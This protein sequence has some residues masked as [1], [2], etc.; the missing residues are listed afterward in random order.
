MADF[1][2]T[3]PT[4]RNLQNIAEYEFD[5][6]DLVRPYAED[7]HQVFDELIA[8]MN[9]ALDLDSR[10][11]S[12]ESADLVGD[13]KI[14]AGDLIIDN[15]YAVRFLNGSG[16]DD[17]TRMYRAPADALWIEYKNNR[18]F[19]NDLDGRGFE[20]RNNGVPVHTID[21]DPTSVASGFVKFNASQMDINFRIMSVNDSSLFHLDAGLDRVGIGTPSPGDLLEVN[22]IL[23]IPGNDGPYQIRAGD[24]VGHGI[25]VRAISNPP[26][27]NPIFAVES[28]GGATRFGVTH[29]VGVWARDG[30]WVG[31]Y[32]DGIVSSEVG[33]DRDVSDFFL[34]A[35]SGELI[36]GDGT[37]NRVGIMTTTP[38]STL[39]VNG[40]ITCSFIDTG[41]GATDV[42]LMNQDVTSL[43]DVLF[44]SVNTGQG[45][46]LLYPMNQGVRTTD[47][48]T[49]NDVTVNGT[50]TGVATGGRTFFNLGRV[51]GDVDNIGGFFFEISSVAGASNK[52][53]VMTRSGTFTDLS[54][55]YDL[56]KT[57]AGVT[58]L[59]IEIL[60][61]NSVVFTFQV[62][63]T[64]GAGKLEHTAN[65]PG[66]PSF[67]AGD[68]VTIGMSGSGGTGGAD[69]TTIQEAQAIF[70]VVFD[71]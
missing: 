51:S 60:V 35:K 37:N 25:V 3:I 24:N 43:D 65:I 15:T 22:G 49:F 63:D 8:V 54:V 61:N 50:L 4:F 58:D 59:F 70:G 69:I 21:T 17:G 1:P 14:E 44:N 18:M 68:Y 5:A 19:L 26:A 38:A 29:G 16:V 20:I 45:A 36:R 27:Q 13:T 67:L 6:T 9:F 56:V 66:S 28:S 11:S 48:V 12:L 40:L 30:F 23:R 2:T 41:Q 46:N 42:Y 71:S 55:S 47:D 32:D 53:I 34:R 33:F 39:D 64:V 10:V 52:G 7:W 57:N 31:S 62:D